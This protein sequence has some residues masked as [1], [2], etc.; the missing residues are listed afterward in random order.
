MFCFHPEPWGND[1]FWRF[2]YFSDGLVQPPTRIICIY[3][4]SY[5]YIYIYTYLEHGDH[6]TWFASTT[7]L[8]CLHHS[9]PHPGHSPHH[10][11]HGRCHLDR[12]WELCVWPTSTVAAQLGAFLG[13][14]C[15]WKRR[16]N[17]W[18]SHVFLG[19]KPGNP[20]L[21]GKSREIPCFFLGMERHPVDSQTSRVPTNFGLIFTQKLREQHSYPIPLPSLKLTVRAWKWMAG[22]LVSFL[23]MLVSGR[24]DCL[25]HRD[26][27]FTEDYIYIYI[28]FF[29]IAM[30][31]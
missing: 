12:L 23:D 22:K 20:M 16:G 7:I 14:F 15:F 10:R 4:R 3:R 27:H 30:A 6:H 18:K 29:S 11:R 13:F 31:T 24:V 9:H 8:P 17:P 26:S 19:E 28:F 5:V 2:A 1:P 25:F 21:F